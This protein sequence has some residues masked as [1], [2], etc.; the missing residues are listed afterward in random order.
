MMIIHHP[1]E[2]SSVL[3]GVKN[4][5]KNKEIV[6]VFQPHRIHE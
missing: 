5:Y 2:I 6:C 1:T 4:V 3:S